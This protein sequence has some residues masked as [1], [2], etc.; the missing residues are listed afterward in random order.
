V[1]RKYKKETIA[2]YD[3]GIWTVGDFI[4]NLYTISRDYF[5]AGMYRAVAMTLRNHFLLQ[6][7]RKKRIDRVQSVRNRINEKREHLASSSY[8]QFYSDTCSFTDGDYRYYYDSIKKMYYNDKQMNVLEIL[9]KSQQQASDIIEKLKAA[10]SSENAFRELARQFTIR[11]GMKEKEGDLGMISS[12]DFGDI[13]KYAAMLNKGGL[14]GPIKTPAGYSIIMQLDYK[15]K[16][17]PFEQVKDDVKKA[18]NE[19]KK[20]FVFQK[21]RRKYSGQ[22]DVVI[23]EDVLLNAF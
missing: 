22:P 11:P 20:S 9:V 18:V 17:I 2:S 19:R 13:G 1:L 4:E 14:A 7:A 10:N 3:G 5:E 16:F 23:H 15:N 21:M 8:I 12:S 6:E